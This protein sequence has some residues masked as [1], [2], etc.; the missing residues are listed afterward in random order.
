MQRIVNECARVLFEGR[1][2]V[3]NISPVLIKRNKVHK[4]SRRLALPFD[5]HTLLTKAGF[6]FIDDIIWLKPEASS[7]NRGKNFYEYR[8]PLGYKT[9]IITEYVLVYRK[10]TEKPVTWLIQNHPDKQAVA[11]SKVADGY[12]ETNVWKI[13]PAHNKKHPAVFPIALAE[14]VITY[15]SF[16]NDVVLDPFGGSGTTARAAANLQRRFVTFEREA[17]YI[18][19]IKDRLN[20]AQYE[21]ILQ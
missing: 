14:R 7:L 19:L 6:D 15:Y 21:S 10:H 13:T 3:L 18:E 12:E 8:N 17:K 5:F 9:N 11:E 16:K 20:D 1:F 2:F 4:N